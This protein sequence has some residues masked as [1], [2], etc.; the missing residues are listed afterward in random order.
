VAVFWMCVTSSAR[1]RARLIA[2]AQQ[3]AGGAHVQGVTED[4]IDLLV[5]TQVGEPVPGEHALDADHQVVTV[6]LDQAQEG[7]GP[8]RDVR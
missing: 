5:G 7:L 4:E 6:R 1:F 3:I 8:S 2:A